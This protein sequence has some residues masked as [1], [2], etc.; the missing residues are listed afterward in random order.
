MTRPRRPGRSAS[1]DFMNMQSRGERQL[2]RPWPVRPLSSRL[3]AGGRT[4]TRCGLGSGAARLGHLYNDSL[5]RGFLR[6]RP[7]A[8]VQQPQRAEHLFLSAWP[9]AME[10][11]KRPVVKATEHVSMAGA[12]LHFKVP[13]MR[14]WTSLESHYSAYHRYNLAVTT[15]GWNEDHSGTAARG[16]KLEPS[17]TFM[18]GHPSRGSYLGSS[19]ITGCTSRHGPTWRYG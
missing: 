4:L 10:A 16:W 19:G 18:D 12:E 3:P 9:S 5:H 6:R 15:K 2:A 14:M 7:P 17:A 11:I 1:L 8:E 13:G